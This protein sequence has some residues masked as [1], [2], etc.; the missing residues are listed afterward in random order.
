MCRPV[1]N[2]LVDRYHSVRPTSRRRSG[3]R[4]E[5]VNWWRKG[6]IVVE[7]EVVSRMVVKAGSDILDRGTSPEE[8][9]EELLEG[10]DVYLTVV[11]VWADWVH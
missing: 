3:R 10:V 4:C 11:L 2:G 5:R 8:V 1:M 6:V 9:A 7:M